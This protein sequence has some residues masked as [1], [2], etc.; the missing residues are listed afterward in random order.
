MDVRSYVCSLLGTQCYELLLLAML[1]GCCLGLGFYFGGCGL[2]QGR[3]ENFFGT[4]TYGIP[5]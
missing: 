2:P 4:H 3:V 5:T 1:I